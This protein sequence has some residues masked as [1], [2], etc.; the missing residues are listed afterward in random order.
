M[1]N[2][3]TQVP[4]YPYM[5]QFARFSIAKEGIMAYS[6]KFVSLTLHSTLTMN[7]FQQ[8]SEAMYV[9]FHGCV[10]NSKSFNASPI[11]KHGDYNKELSV[12]KICAQQIFLSK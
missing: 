11:L 2:L 8:Q 7:I 6:I 5:T 10:N 1:G 12:I 3:E 4:K 9:M